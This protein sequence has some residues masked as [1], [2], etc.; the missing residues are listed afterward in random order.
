MQT[1]TLYIDIN[2]IYILCHY[3]IKELGKLFITLS[4]VSL[5][6]LLLHSVHEARA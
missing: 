1:R 4:N 6:Y 5:Y 2:G 3:L